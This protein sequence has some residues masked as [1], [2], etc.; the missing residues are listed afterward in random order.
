MFQKVGEA[1][2]DP[3]SFMN[4]AGG[5]PKLDGN[6]GGSEI[7]LDKDAKPIFKLSNLDKRR[8]EKRAMRTHRDWES[9]FARAMGSFTLTDSGEVTSKI[10]GVEFLSSWSGRSMTEG[11][12]LDLLDLLIL[13]LLRLAGGGFNPLPSPLCLIPLTRVWPAC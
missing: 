3:G 10:F 6:D 13:F 4:T 12:Y 9:I 5:A 11:L 1:G 7:G 8:G 2:A